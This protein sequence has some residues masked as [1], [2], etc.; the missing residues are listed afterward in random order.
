MSIFAKYAD[1]HTHIL[2]A[3]PD[4]IINLPLGANVPPVGSYSVGV[5][6]WEADANVDWVQ[7][8]EAAEKP[9]V[10]AIGEV[11]LDALR[12]PDLPIQERTFIRQALLAE[13]LGK[14]LIIHC[15]R[16]YGRLLEL[17]RELQPKQTWLV[18]GFRGK[19][20]L[21]RQL[22]AAGFEISIGSRYNPAVPA[23]VPTHLLHHETD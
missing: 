6:P 9:Q 16:A 14:P 12:G 7:L 20:E 17:R 19:P 3:G 8:R 13:E 22:T 21:A 10:V 11:G 23:S 5:H 2:D 1:V 18:H 15:V 4:A